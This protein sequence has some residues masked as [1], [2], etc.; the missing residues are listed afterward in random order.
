MTMAV[1]GMGQPPDNRSGTRMKNII[2]QLE[3]IARSGNN[4][5]ANSR[6]LKKGLGGLSQYRS[7]EVSEAEC[8]DVVMGV[9]ISDKGR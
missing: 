2:G 6:A 8:E 4:H 1:E 5:Q 9:N 3:T 7:P